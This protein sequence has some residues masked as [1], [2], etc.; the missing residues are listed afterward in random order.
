[1][2]VHLK[3]LGPLEVWD[4]I[5]PRKIGGA[6][7]RTLLVLLALH[8]GGVVSVDAIA[9]A[10]WG[11]DPPASA[12]K[13]IPVLVTRLRKALAAAPSVPIDIE[14][15]GDGYR[16]RMPSGAIDAVVAEDLARS[17]G[18]AKD[19]GEL[20]Q[21]AQVLSRAQGLWRGPSLAGVRDEPFA[22]PDAQRLDELRTQLLEDFLDVELQRGRHDAVL[23]D[24]E[25]ACASHPLRE[26]LWA[27]RMLGLHRAGRT[28]EALRAYQTVRDVMVEEVGLDPSEE[29]RE[30]EAAILRDD[31]ALRTA[32]RR[33]LPEGEIT[34]LLTDVA[35]STRLW[36]RAPEAMATALA[37]HDELAEQVVSQAGGVVLKSRG[38]GDSTFCVFDD[39]V[40]ATNAA[41]R[42][43]D[44]LTH[45][46]WPVDASIRVRMAVH[47]GRAELRDGDYF[48]PTV[49]RVARLRAAGHGGQIL[50][51]AAT[52]ALARDRLP[53]GV[54][55]RDLGLRRLKDLLEPEHIFQVEHPDL[56]DRFPPLAT[57]D[58]RPNNLPL[59]PTTFVG[60][61]ATVASLTALLRSRDVRL[62][63]L[64]G[65]GGIGKTRLAL[66]AAADVVDD[67]DDGVWFVP[68]APVETADAVPAA[69]AA[70]LDAHPEQGEAI[71]DTLVRHV[72]D[73]RMLLVLDNFE[74]VMDAVELVAE[75]YAR[76]PAVTVLA[77]SREWLHLRAEHEVRV[78]PLDDGTATALFAERARAVRLDA[79]EW[80]DATTVAGICRALD[81]LPLAVELVAARLRTYDLDELAAQ[82][83]AVLDVAAD[84]PRD[85]PLRHQTLRDTIAWSIGLLSPGER[86]ALLAL[87]VFRGGWTIAAAADVVADGDVD[88]AAILLP[89]LADKSLVAQSRPGRYDMLETI[90]AHASEQL[91]QSPAELARARQAHVDHWVREAEAWSASGGGLDESWFEDVTPPEASALAELDNRRAALTYGAEASSPLLTVRAVR[92]ILPVDAREALERTEA[93]RRPDDE[94]WTYWLELCRISVLWTLGRWAE[95]EEGAQRLLSRAARI[96]PEGVPFIL[97]FVGIAAWRLGRLAEA[98]A[99]LERGLAAL[100]PDD[101]AFRPMLL[102]NRGLVAASGNDLAAAARWYEGA[103]AI[104]PTDAAL[105][106]IIDLRL[107]GLALDRGLAD[108]AVRWLSAVLDSEQPLPVTRVMATDE[109]VRALIATGD[110][111]AALDLA[112]RTAADARDWQVHAQITAG[113]ALG[114]AR[115]AAGDLA[116][117]EAALE[118]ADALGARAFEVDHRRLVTFLLGQTRRGARQPDGRSSGV[119]RSARQRSSADRDGRPLRAGPRRARLGGRCGGVGSLCGRAPAAHG[120]G[121]PCQRGHRL[122]L[123]GRPRR[124][125]GPGRPRGDAPRRGRVLP[126]P[127][128]HRAAAAGQSG[129]CGRSSSHWLRR[130]PAGGSV[131]VARRSRRARRG[132]GPRRLACRHARRACRRPPHERRRGPDVEPREG[133]GAQLGVRQRHDPRPGARRRPST[134]PT[135]RGHRGRPPAPPAGRARA[136]PPSAARVAGRPRLR[137]RLPRPPRGPPRAGQRAAAVRPGVFAGGGAVRPH[138]P[139][140]GVHDR[141]RPRGRAG[142]ARSR[143]CTTRSPTARAASACRCSSSTSTA[144]APAPGATP[145]RRNRSPMR[146]AGEPVVVRQRT[147][148]TLGHNVRRAAR[149]RPPRGRERGRRAPPPRAARRRRARRLPRPSGPSGPADRSGRHAR[150]PLWTERSLRRRFEM[151]RVPLDDAKRTAK[152]LG[153]SVNDVFV[154]GAAGA[155]GAYHRAKGADVDELR[156]SMPVSTRSDGPVG[157]NAFAPSR[158]LLPVDIEDPV[159]RFAAVR[160]RLAVTKRERA[161]GLAGALAGV[162]NVL[163]TSVLV[164]FARQQIETVDFATVNVRG[165][166]FDLYIAGARIEANYPMGPLAGT[167]FNVTLLSYRGS[168]DMGINIDPV[169]RSRT[170]S[171]SGPAWSR[172]SWTCSKPA[173]PTTPMPAA[174]VPSVGGGLG[175]WPGAAQTARRAAGR[176]PRRWRPVHDGACRPGRGR[177]GPAL[178]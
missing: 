146:P 69:V 123:R 116:G 97:N 13:G 156:I 142:R 92:L 140:V 121:S 174:P 44:A 58:S 47:T 102:H 33:Q 173:E 138:A 106:P 168:L 141:R 126:N 103:R 56:P 109:M 79:D 30:L 119:L 160:E 34:F 57:L 54:S 41:F 17:A 96:R 113:A 14:R 145:R 93:A 61:D 111:E 151:L 132:V 135:R 130:R 115:L 15:V 124:G 64:T 38:E 51:S 74:H 71:V 154:T 107:G 49:N 81:G 87:S 83:R 137:H 21:A 6:K 167:A 117:A 45:E 166:P 35:G 48:G 125:G 12:V 36:E 90:R 37:R 88:E 29:L 89:S 100:S 73:R 163:P 42:F 177:S 159:A 143:R 32:Q 19:A 68:L 164:R 62:V 23:A 178:R 65:P 91:D 76:C 28:P 82:L 75:L 131:P 85:Q 172:L 40:R 150:S 50:L 25:A 158:V 170:P 165:A 26:R 122:L 128:G 1:M 104:G 86:D 118:D 46:P 55:L 9:D 95:V 161:L 2:D 18:L 127:G 157:G 99:A 176:R 171:C 84:G 31:P 169:P 43:Q 136:G 67:F 110:V 22:V 105:D 147:L 114:R 7:E 144:R 27:L 10:L 20:D 63:T 39:P 108:E 120:R 4:G 16:L 59:Q 153:G 112:V 149:H 80:L 70:A 129:R 5:A 152:A 52:A 77:T 78:P 139:A 162:M 53:G 155:A 133:S 8:A 66:R 60:R 101:R 3:L 175:R 98:D 72:S 11:D 148:E 94:T 24:L 134:R